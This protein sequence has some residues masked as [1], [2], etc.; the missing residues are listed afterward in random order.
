M[1]YKE[2]KPLPHPLKN[3]ANISKFNKKGSVLLSAPQPAPTP[4]PREQRPT[5]VPS[6]VYCSNHPTVLSSHKINE[7]E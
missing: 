3:I 2:N 4:E 7:E 5:I 1:N 6:I